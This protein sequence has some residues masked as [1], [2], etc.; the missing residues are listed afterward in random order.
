LIAV[1]EKLTPKRGTEALF[2][3]PDLNVCL[4]D[5]EHIIALRRRHADVIR[6]AAAE[7]THVLALNV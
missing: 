2:D 3:V 7:F 5:V 6:T 1:A 4:E